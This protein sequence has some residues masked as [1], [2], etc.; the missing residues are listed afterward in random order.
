[1]LVIC[2]L[3]KKAIAYFVSAIISLLLPFPGLLLL[4]TSLLGTIL[5]SLVGFL[6][7][8]SLLG[9][10]WR[11]GIDSLELPTLS[12]RVLLRVVLNLVF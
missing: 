1:L 9:F 8:K 12:I 7:Y 5:E 4:S 10:L 2:H 11:I 3:I 6:P